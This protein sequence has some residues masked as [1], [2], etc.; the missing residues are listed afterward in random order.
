MKNKLLELGSRPKRIVKRI[1]RNVLCYVPPPKGRLTAPLAIH[2]GS[3]VRNTRFRPWPVFPS[4]SVGESLFRAGPALTQIFRTGQEGLPQNLAKEFGEQWAKYCGVKHALLLPHGTDALRIG[5]AAALNQDGLKYGG[6]IL[7]PNISFIA[8]A[9]AALDRR[10]GVALVDVDPKTLNIDPNRAEE[11]IVYGKTKAIM[12]VD[13][14]GQP[15]DFASLREIARKYSL[16]LIED[17]AQAHGAMHGLGRA[18][19]LGHV[20]AFSFQTYKNLPAGEG[21]ALTTNDSAIFECAYSLHDVGRKLVGSSRWAH[22]TLGWNCRPSEYVAAVL[23][24]RL[25]SLESQQQ[26]RWQRFQLLRRL[27]QDVSAVECLAVGP[28]VVRHGVHVF[29]MRYCKQHCGGLELSDFV[30]AV[31]A[32]GVPISR[33]YEKTLAQQT[34][35]QKLAAERPEYIRVCQTPVA[36]E[37]VKNLVFLPHQ[38]FLAS[39]DEVAEVAAA[40]RKVEAYYTGRKASY[41]AAASPKDESTTRKQPQT[42]LTSVTSPAAAPLRIGI[43]GAGYMGLEHA[44]ALSTAGS[45]KIAAFSDVERKIGRRAAENYGCAAFE[46]AEELVTHGDVNAVVVA[47]PHWQH[48]EIARFAL[49]NGLHV[50]CEKP[51]TVTVEQADQLLAVASETQR[52]FAVVHQMRFEPSY[53]YVKTLLDSSDLGSVYRC[54]M[55]ESMWRTDAYY[56]SSPWR[57]TWQGEG[58]GVLLNQAPHT[59]D[60]YAWLFGMPTSVIGK[61]DTNLH[62][63]EVEDTVSAIF[64]H[65]NGV[66]GSLHVNTV[67]SPSVSE[68]V[69]CCDRGRIVSDRGKVRVTRL[70]SSIRDVTRH[71]TAFWGELQSETQE[72]EFPFGDALGSLLVEFYRNFSDAVAGRS[73][74][75]CP[76]REGRNAV[77]LANAIILSSA[78][79]RELDLP[80]DR[81]S[82][83]SFIESR[84][85]LVE[86]SE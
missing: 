26:I 76:G 8:S 56:K 86:A 54:A 3:P 59:L 60:R 70:K 84:R 4:V 69:I 5:V 63:I 12:A 57:G 40:F 33:A 81:V 43:I 73:R 39:E 29:G 11:A 52:L 48:A 74:L 20:A 83:T 36:D 58:G 72:L 46:S 9:N 41:L 21:G 64:R 50:I 15:A 1:A 61:C 47:T 32:E 6:E 44:K 42:M 17:A 7:V 13:L 66:H 75:M 67:E 28:G 31:R 23:L 16:V 53:Q 19:S 22:E 10:V 45:F 27:L 38:M 35:M 78:E 85:G 62:P 25:K 79:K 77:E 24:H 2:G 14:F 82:Y 51:L 30:K 18:G 55:V 68:I 71:E 37:A 34:A 49:Q 80:I 65:E